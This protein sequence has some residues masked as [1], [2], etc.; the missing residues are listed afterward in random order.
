MPA[1]DISMLAAR[2]DA[3]LRENT[4]STVEALTRADR[5]R[6]I[7]SSTLVASSRIRR[8]I[9]CTGTPATALSLAWCRMLKCSPMPA[10]FTPILP[11]MPN[12][13]NSLTVSPELAVS[14]NSMPWGTRESCQSQV[15]M[16]LGASAPA[17]ACTAVE[18]SPSSEAGITARISVRAFRLASCHRAIPAPSAVASSSR[19][20]LGLQSVSACRLASPIERTCSGIT[21]T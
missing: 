12:S 21:P 18:H 2:G 16:V 10:L 19:A 1:A 7:A 8:A 4:V 5:A 15:W 20:R 3:S 17:G 11:S 14:C 13:V 9:A 6:A